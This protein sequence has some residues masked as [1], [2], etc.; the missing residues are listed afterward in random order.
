MIRGTR[1][2]MDI[3]KGPYPGTLISLKCKLT[4]EYVMGWLECTWCEAIDI[5]SS[6]TPASQAV[7]PCSVDE[8][9]VWVTNIREAV[10]EDD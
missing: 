8:Y 6:G 10:I 2:Y 4:T 7:L 5:L 1:R 3:E 9:R